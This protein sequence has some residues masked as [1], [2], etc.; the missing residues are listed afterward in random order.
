MKNASLS[1][2]MS[3][4][5]DLEAKTGEI[6]GGARPYRLAKIRDLEREILDSAS[7][8]GEERL[9][10]AYRLIRALENDWDIDPVLLLLRSIE[11]DLIS[12]VAADQPRPAHPPAPG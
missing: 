4:L 8:S 5:D 11:L 1:S 6:T 2:K 9:W 12:T 10:K 3:A 7:C